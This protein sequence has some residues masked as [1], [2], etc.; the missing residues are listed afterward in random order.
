MSPETIALRAERGDAK[1]PI[2]F[3]A[4]ADNYVMA[5]RPGAMPFVEPLKDWM[6]R[7][8]ETH[9]KPLR[10]AY[11]RALALPNQGSEE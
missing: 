10:E 11:S 4:E 7:P 3:M 1:G 8:L 5:R 9:A 6:R 2:R